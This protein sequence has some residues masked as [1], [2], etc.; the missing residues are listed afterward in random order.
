M[1]D[2]AAA[3]RRAS[4]IETTPQMCQNCFRTRSDRIIAAALLAAT[5]LVAP[6]RAAPPH[7]QSEIGEARRLLLKGDYAEAGEAYAK[8]A[9]MQ[10]VIA[11]IGQARSL[12]AVGIADKAT[13]ALTAA[14]KQ[15]P[16]AGELH[17]EMALLALNRGDLNEA[18]RQADSAL[19]LIP[20]G[21]K[22]AAARWI[23]AELDRRAGKLEA[24]TAEYKWL[25]DLY[26]R[27][28][29]IDDP[30][31][32]RYIGLGA[33]QYARWKRQSDQFNVLVNDFYPELLKLDP[34]FWPA[35]YE[36]GQLYAEKFNEADALSE[37][38]AALALN[39]NA[40]EVHAAIASLA[41]ENYD[42]AAAQA[43]I[44]RALAI[45]PSLLSAHQL[46]ADVD[47]ANFESAQALEHL[48]AAL[49]LDPTNESTLGRIAA[50]Y[51]ALDGNLMSKAAAANHSDSRAGRLIT[52]VA[53]RDPH[54]GEFFAAMAAGL[55][56][57]QRYPDS[58][59]YYQAAIDRMPQ[60]I[61]PRGDLGMVYMRLGDEVAAGQ[62]LRKAFAID[63]FNLRVSNMLKVLDVL[64][65]YSIIETEHFVIKFDRTHDA[66]LAKYAAKF[67]EQTVYPSLV[68]KLGYRPSG[69]SLFEIFNRARNTDGHGW[70]SARMV[71]LPYIGTV[72]ACAGRIVAMQSPNDGPAKFN[73]ARVLRHEFVHVVNLQQTNFNVPHWFTEA[74][75]V[76][77][78]GYPHPRHWDELLA[79][80]VPQGNLFNLETIN[81]GFIRPSSSDDWAMAYC[82][83]EFYAQYMLDRF[84]H[85]ALA[86]MLAAY[87]DDL[88]TRAA[89]RRALGVDQAEFERGYLEYL[90]GLA[91][92]FAGLA[93]RT[94]PDITALEKLH[95][96]KPDDLE[97]AS[98]LA[99]A[100]LDKRKSK[101]AESLAD[102]VLQKSPKQ[103]LASYVTARMAVAAGDKQK[104]IQ[105]LEKALDRDAPQE[106]VLAL[107]AGLKSDVD[108]LAAEEL[109]RLG[110]AKFPQDDQW[111]KALARVYLKSGNEEKLFDVLAQLAD[112]DPD[113]IVMR[114]KL[115]QIALKAKHFDAAEHWATE[116]LYVDVQDA[117]AHRM[118]AEALVGRKE[119]ASAAP[120]YETAVELE[121]TSRAMQ[122]ELADAYLR[123]GQKDRARKLLHEILAAEPD[124]PGAAE[125]LKEAEKQKQ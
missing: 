17:A 20:E 58:V 65:D 44:D 24:A 35:H 30:E 29:S 107:L 76:L 95:A 79:E 9:A 125:L 75:A 70:F 64:N 121:P 87:A 22:Q 68:Q 69:K 26:N 21:P 83:A 1:S 98:R 36:A 88:N 117:D 42:L 116:A 80:R 122:F 89:I 45:D 38:N 50:A 105:V 62:E 108:P 32:L 120:E 48:H 96:A 56:R 46:Q 5:I 92:R 66:L 74:L 67:L 82:Q 115:A 53:A 104:A 23:I 124:F 55:D 101:K 106:N 40:A 18:R 14:L 100:W 51:V 12:A 81:G 60:L 52:E 43:S 77:N 123:A 13:E 71:G 28:N 37:F 47:L 72:G 49:K 61:G 73:W 118:L 16:A 4:E 97:I 31:A 114:K 33:A 34:T 84:G 86:K 111:S 7:G 63:P 103:P 94:E 10:P 54:C 6:S 93:P 78:E 19:R 91:A 113:N 109:Y 90:R 2:F 99:F 27:E 11:A 39:P 102:S 41:L 59:Q 57:L 112:G 85:D 25:V 15:N 8:L 110:A 119:Y 3:G